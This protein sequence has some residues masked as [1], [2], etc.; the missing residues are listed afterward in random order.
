V[1]WVINGVERQFF[2]SLARGVP[3]GP[4]DRTVDPRVVLGSLPFALE[5]A[6]P[7]VRRLAAAGPR[8][9]HGPDGFLCSFIR[10]F[11]VEGSP[12]GWWVTPYRVSIDQGPVV[13][14]I[15]NHRTG[16]L[17]DLMRRCAPVVT[18]LRRAG[19][20]GGGL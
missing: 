1:K 2:D 12:A 3:F 15:E 17:W 13:L 4:D 14:P 19:F 11:G 20:T 8:G 7:T 16:V 18:G 6:L 10:T 9:L 5:T